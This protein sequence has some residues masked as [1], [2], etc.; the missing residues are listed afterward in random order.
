LSLLAATYLAPCNRPLYE[1][2]AQACGASELVDGADWR[3]LEGGGID[4]AFVCSP[5]MIWLGGA[6]EAI[7]APVLTD[8]RFGGKPLY[9]SEVIVH[10]NSRFQS[11]ED[12]RGARWAINEPSSW[13]G[14]WVTLQRVRSWD[15]FGEVVEAGFHEAALRMVAEGKID[16]AAIDC[17][18][19]DVVRRQD[20]TLAEKLKVVE[21][22]GPSPSQPVVV[23]ASLDAGLKARIRE[24]L[25]G[26]RDPLM[27]EF[28]LEGF[29]LPPDYSAIATAVGVS[30]R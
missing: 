18:V 23:R 27:N 24:R 19:L 5:P 29:A 16:G 15:F 9:S 8:S 28:G 21:F 12:L 22:L 14:Y 11:L 7:A 17:H 1:F 30:L 13:S 10:R 6:V 3:E 25:L 2:V 20:P 26:L 4:L